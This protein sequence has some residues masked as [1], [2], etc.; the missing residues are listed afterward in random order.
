MKKTLII[1]STALDIIINLPKIPL[2]SEDVHIQSQT[3]SI[4]GC[5]YN[6]AFVLSL[7]DL[8]HLFCSPVG[9]GMYGNYVAQ[10]MQKNKM[11]PFVRI[12]E[13]DNGC[14]YCFVEK[15]GE[16]TFLS[17]HGVEYSFS[18]EWLLHVDL[19]EYSQVYICGL[20]IE[21]ET[22]NELISFLE[23]HPHFTV[24]FAP[25]PRINSIDRDKMQRLFALHPILHL[26]EDEL[27]SFTKAADIPS[28]LLHLYHQ[29]HNTI[30]VTAAKQGAFLFENHNMSHIPSIETTVVNTIG[31]GDSHIG[32]ILAM[33]QKGSSFLDAVK[34][35]NRVSAKVV[36]T[37]TSTLTKEAFLSLDL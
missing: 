7:F 6:A 36:S 13:K 14:C 24:Y 30:I 9:S 32:T 19:S 22:G 20:E 1:G 31:A 3:L 11:T 26:N 35:A 2:T 10:Q 5:A 34:A 28:G 8:P 4:G 17:F 18:K 21:E 37:N 33:R 23:E 25:G 27:L 16:R 29:T 15:N 12:P